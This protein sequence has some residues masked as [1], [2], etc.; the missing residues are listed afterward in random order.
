MRI[1]FARCVVKIPNYE[2]ACINYAKKKKLRHNF[3]DN[4]A[5]HVFS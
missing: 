2:N 4:Y 5:N 3:C 1:Q